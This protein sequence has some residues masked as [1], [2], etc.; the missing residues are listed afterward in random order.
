MTIWRITIGV[1]IALLIA[2]GGWGMQRTATMSDRHPTRFEFKYI[3]ESIDKL[4]VKIDKILDHL[5]KGE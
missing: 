4:D 5:I 2:I 1:I 3:Q